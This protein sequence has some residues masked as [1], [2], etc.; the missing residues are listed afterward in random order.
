MLKIYIRFLVLF[1]LPTLTA[2]ADYW[3]QKANFAGTSRQRAT[4]FSIGT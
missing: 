1:T 3:T 4:S 2:Q